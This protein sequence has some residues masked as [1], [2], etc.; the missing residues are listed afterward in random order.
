MYNI[1]RTLYEI[2]LTCELR[3]L[4]RHTDSTSSFFQL[5]NTEILKAIYVQPV[6]RHE[7]RLGVKQQRT[8]QN[9]PG[10]IMVGA[11]PRNSRT[12]LFKRLEILPFPRK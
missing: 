12:N 4:A 7:I 11:K 1:K 9:K 8:L 6:I 3:Q 2:S 5:S 10:R